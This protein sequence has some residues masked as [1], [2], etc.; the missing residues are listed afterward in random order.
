VTMR[1]KQMTPAI[2]YIS[3]NTRP[4]RISQ[5]MFRISRS[6]PRSCLALSS[7]RTPASRGPRGEPPVNMIDA[8][9]D[10]ERLREVVAG[11][12]VGEQALRDHGPLPQQQRVAE[13]R[14]DLL[15]VVRDEHERR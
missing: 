2:A 11:H 13:R 14:R 4:P 1:M 5:R 12:G 6:V 10:A 15:H 9:R 3:A 8:Q 7:P